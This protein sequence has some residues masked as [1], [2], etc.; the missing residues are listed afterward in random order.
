MYPADGPTNALS[1]PRPPASRGSPAAARARSTIIDSA[2]RRGPSTAPASITPK[3]CAVI[4]TPPNTLK[5]PGRPSAAASAAN[6]ATRAMSCAS[7]DH[8]R[9]SVLSCFWVL[10]VLWVLSA[11]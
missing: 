9:P 2:P 7:S 11:I 6:T 8:D 4:G 3:V 5:L 10:W 1:P